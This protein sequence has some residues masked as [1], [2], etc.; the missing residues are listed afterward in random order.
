MVINFF[1]TIAASDNPTFG[2]NLYKIIKF[3]TLAI[4]IGVVAVPEGLP[5][6]IGISL[7]YSTKKMKENHI[8]VKRL[9]ST[10]V[11][12]TVQEIVTGK[13]GT[14]TSE[15]MNVAEW[16]AFGQ[17]T[18][19]T[20]RNTMCSSGLADAWIDAMTDA[21]LFNTEARIEMG[22][23]ATYVPVGSGTETCMLKFLQDN[24][25]PVHDLIKKKLD[26]VLAT[27][28]HSSARKRMTTAVAHPED[29][30]RVRVVVKGAPELLLGRCTRT[31]D[32]EGHMQPLSDQE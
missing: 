22:E 23:E 28:P 18:K 20:L 16:Y 27:L 15:D 24:Q 17:V 6:S 19:N 8:L 32:A 4:V 26:N 7:A 12:G 21:I 31:F 5:L 25:L 10:E 1:I 13:T 2:N 14:L 9:E 11:M 29:P 30:E 3:L